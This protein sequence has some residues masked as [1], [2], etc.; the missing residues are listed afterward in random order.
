MNSSKRKLQVASFYCGAGGL[1]HGFRRAGTETLLAN[2]LDPLAVET[3]RSLNQTD[4]AFAGDVHGI[5]LDEAQG[6]DLVIGG[7]PCQGFSVAGKM[8]PDDPRSRHVWTFLSLVSK[9]KP[10]AFV[11]EN[12]RN[13]AE[14]RRW[15]DLRQGL[16]VSANSMGYSTRLLLLNAADF[17]VPQNRYRMFLLGVRGR[18][19][20]IPGIEAT[21][22]GDPTSVRKAF[23]SLPSYGEEGNSTFCTAKITIAAKPVL[24]RSPYAGM[25]FN[26]AGRPLDLDRPST[27]L[28]ASMGGNRTPII[29]QNL[30]DGDHKSWVRD[31]H[32][33]LW[34][35][36]APLP[37]ESTPD[38]LRRLTVEEAS[39]IQGFPVGTSWSGKTSAKFRQIGNA[40]PPPLA[41][42]VARHVIALVGNAG[43]QKLVPTLD[44]CEVLEAGMIP[45]SIEL[46]AA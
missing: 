35:G 39:V 25:L 11:M 15:S 45:S 28:A 43:P 46:E 23:A 8:D 13:L 18:G 40:V 33:H 27:T 34:D 10:A 42:A 21:L 5:D 22:K 29:E 9:I 6:A 37:F 4:R 30:L 7:P 2:D 16:E 19:L 12:V 44:E 3:F 1:D 14:N 20:T 17:G 36:G 26:G 24:R 31:Y 32:A 38:L 41:E